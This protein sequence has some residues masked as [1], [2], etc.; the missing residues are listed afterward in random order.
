VFELEVIAH[1][2]DKVIFE[3]SLDELVEKIWS[4]DFINIRAGKVFGEGLN[5][6]D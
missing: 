6:I 5:K 3:D 1:P 2:F 4:Y